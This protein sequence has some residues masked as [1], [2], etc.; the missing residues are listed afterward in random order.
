MKSVKLYT[1]PHCPYCNNAKQLLKDKNV[2]FS[3]VDIYG[4]EEMR[5]ALT[6]KTGQRTVPYVFIDDEFIGGFSELANLDHIGKLDA[7]LA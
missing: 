6:E 7:L 5:D 4:N 3:D 1:W 2:A